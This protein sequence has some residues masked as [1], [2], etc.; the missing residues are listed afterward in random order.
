[1]LSPSPIKEGSELFLG[2]AAAVGTDLN[3]VTDVLSEALRRLHYEPHKIHL[4]ALLNELP[5]YSSK[6]VFAPADKY[7]DTHMTQGDELRKTTGRNDALALLAIAEIQKQRQEA[8]LSAGKALARHAYILRSLKHPDEVA[9][10][11]DIYGHSF[12]LLAAYAPH[13]QRR[14]H[15]AER[16]ARAYNDASAHKYLSHAEYLILRDQEEYG[17]PHGQNVRDTYHRADV[18]LHTTGVLPAHLH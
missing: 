13:D 10:L 2:V 16:I 7:I 8:G 18:F 11:R 1:M 4:A 9:A 14:D 17:L 12:Y 3:L 5:D 15:L 6:L